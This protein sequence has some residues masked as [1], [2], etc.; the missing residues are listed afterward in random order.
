MNLS[1]RKE[2]INEEIIYP[3]IQN[4]KSKRNKFL[5]NN[6]VG[7]MKS[8]KYRTTFNYF[9]NMEI[10]KVKKNKSNA[11]SLKVVHQEDK[12]NKL[13]KSMNKS[14]NSCFHN[15]TLKNS[16]TFKKSKKSANND[17]TED[18]KNILNELFKIKQKINEINTIK[19]KKLKNFCRVHKSDED[20][21]NMIK[22]VD[23]EGEIFKSNTKPKKVK[24][25][26][27]IIN[28]KNSILE[29]INKNT[30]K[31]NNYETENNF[32]KLKRENKEKEIQQKRFISSNKKQKIKLKMSIEALN[33]EKTSEGNSS[34]KEISKSID[35][36]MTSY[37]SNN[38]MYEQIEQDNYIDKIRDKAFIDLYNKFK[39]SMKKSKKEEINHRKSL[40]FPTET[41][42]YIIKMKNEL[43]IDKYRNEYLKRFDNYKYNKRNIFRVINNCKKSEI[44]DIE[45]SENTIDKSSIKIK[46]NQKIEEM[47]E[48]KKNSDNISN[49]YCDE[50]SFNF[51]ENEL[52]EM[53]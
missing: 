8:L 32:N 10:K 21:R 46:L 11:K 33:K 36:T 6:I 23:T 51:S 20:K 14:L 17:N 3:I 18:M 40:V 38:I 49:N 27:K 19:K 4:K 15:N 44:K 12:Y 31:I 41:V 35:K 37:N 45:N 1:E 26:L 29:K 34:K 47:E 7:T 5:D 2:S 28:N 53:H 30:N 42:D 9:N 43:I 48:N 39:K 50:F 25:R 16:I 22:S 24:Y 13:Q 52:L